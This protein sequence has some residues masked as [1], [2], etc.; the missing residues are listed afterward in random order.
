LILLQEI[1]QKSLMGRVPPA[2]F[3][4]LEGFHI[5][6]AQH[7]HFLPRVDFGLGQKIN[8]V[9]ALTTAAIVEVA[10]CW[11]SGGKSG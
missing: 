8:A 9:V 2:L 11:V 6:V 1:K 10:S 7:C 3:V 4:G 5:I